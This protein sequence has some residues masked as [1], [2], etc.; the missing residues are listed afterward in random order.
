MKPYET[1]AILAGVFLSACGTSPSTRYYTLDAVH[2]S[3]IGTSIPAETPVAIQKVVLPSIL[4][5]PELVRRITA[6]RLDIDEVDRWAA[7]LDDLTQNVLAADLAAKMPAGTSIQPGE[8]LPPGT[9]RRVFVDI[10]TFEGDLAGRVVLRAQWTVETSSADADLEATSHSEDIVV[11]ARS[12]NAD[13]VA[14][15]MSEA[16]SE[17]A[18]RMARALNE[19]TDTIGQASTGKNARK[20]WN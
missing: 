11:E 7:P 13:G 18:D 19:P 1:I 10:T 8:P 12:D 15:G 14:A 2:G 3:A 16:L 5:R 9:T 4:D 20:L 17:L 6:N